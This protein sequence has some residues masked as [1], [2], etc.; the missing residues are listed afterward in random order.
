MQNTFKNATFILNPV[1]GK[2]DS[3]LKIKEI[4]ECAKSLGWNGSYKETTK[5]RG[6]SEI[7]QEEIKKGVKH[8]VVCG[9]DGSIMEVLSCVIKEDIVLGIVPLGTG[10]LL[11]RNL[12]LPL[13][14]KE[15]VKVAL[16]GN[17]KKIDIGKMNEMHFSVIAGIGLDAQIMKKTSREVKDKVGILAY[18][19]SAFQNIAF[20]SGYYEVRLDKKKPFKVSAK[21]IMA[22]NMGKIMGGIEVVPDTD[23]QSGKLQLGI[24][25]TTSFLSWMI[26]LFHAV[27]S[28]VDKSPHVDVYEA[29]TINI[30]SLRG[31]IAYQCDGDSFASTDTFKL[32]LIPQAVSIRVP[33]HMLGKKNEQ[34]KVLLFD[35]DG[36]LADSL[37]MVLTIYNILAQKHNYPRISEKEKEKMRDMSARELLK[38]LPISK[39]K[40]P[41]LYR[42]GKEE[43]KKR[44]DE[45]LLFK[46]LEKVILHLSQKYTLG[47]VTSNDPIDVKKFLVAHK[48]DHFAFVYS[49][50]S[51]FG[52]GK[53]IKDVLKKYEYENK[54]V[55]YIGDEVRD[56]DAAREAGIRSVSVTWGFNSKKSL[57]KNKPDFFVDEPE[58]LI[59]RDFFL[60]KN[61]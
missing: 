48:V 19:L 56:I 41:L 22:A 6:A 12:S 57:L 17:L 11:A 2:G 59:K 8:L 29:K 26:T 20:R 13:E 39:F 5:T 15:A 46:D 21:T 24:F 40:I 50:G 60:K 4:K 18:V 34:K 25:K 36:T 10:N 23:A 47:I 52:K 3:R 53:I 16:F 51:I 45:I 32:S 30:R 7:A 58:E 61:T 27:L 54:N 43:F 1:S 14:I 9:G 44:F 42:E 37:E 33:E 55:V 49:D 31:K 28:S 35:F 38:N